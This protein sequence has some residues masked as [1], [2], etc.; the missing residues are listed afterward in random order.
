[1]KEESNEIKVDLETRLKLYMPALFRL[2][3]DDNL[4][5]RQWK[6]LNN[7]FIKEYNRRKSLYEANNNYLLVEANIY[8]LISS[9]LSGNKSAFRLIGYFD[10]L[11]KGLDNNLLAEEKRLIR[12]TLYDTLINLDHTFRNFIGE[13]SVL[14][15]LVD[16]R[17][18]GLLGIEKDFIAGRKTADFTVLDNTT[19]TIELVE[20]VNIHFDQSK[21]LKE[22]LTQK[23]SNKIVDKTQNSESFKPF[24]LVPVIWAPVEVLKEIATLYKTDVSMKIPGS[25][26]P[27]AYCVFEDPNGHPVYR[28]AHISTLFPDGQIT[29][30]WVD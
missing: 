29:V 4:N 25:H 24:T 20:V 17:R 3:G 16:Q 6:K 1:M 30:Q 22:N 7:K 19:N 9:M 10:I 28:F 11:F 21:Y 15:N 8:D 27:L 5:S 18:Y 23:I 13:L 2:L 14:L 12:D 26:E